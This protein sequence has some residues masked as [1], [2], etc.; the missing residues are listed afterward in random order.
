MDTII[1]GGTFNPVHNGHLQL[2]EEASRQF[3]CHRVLFVPANKP[4]HK[5]DGE[6]I[7]NRHRVAMLEI[8]LEGTGWEI[9]ECELRRGGVS[10]MIDTVEELAEAGRWE[11]APG[12][13][14]GDD[15]INGFS[16]WKRADELA[17]RVHLI[18]GFRDQNR[19]MSLN[20]RHSY[21]KNKV[22][23]ISSSEIRERIQQQE[24]YRYLVPKGVYEYIE[25]YGLYRQKDGQKV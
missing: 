9:E 23:P 4:A 1:L 17:E 13:V 21:L 5:S 16:R 6:I 22:L 10:Y 19:K 20:Y 24:A 11:E 8:A 12:L 14:I 15:L 18:L 2:A 3:R 7:S 25:N